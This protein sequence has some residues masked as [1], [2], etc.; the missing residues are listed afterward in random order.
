ME[1]LEKNA[2]HHS[3]LRPSLVVDMNVENVLH[4]NLL[5][6]W[7]FFWTWMQNLENTLVLHNKQESSEGTILELSPTLWI[8]LREH[9]GTK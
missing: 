4:N 3:G 2:A 1:I 6:F 9:V 7:N 8:L 5:D